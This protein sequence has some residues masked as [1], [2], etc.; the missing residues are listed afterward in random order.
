M[1]G[2]LQA[3]RLHPLR[4]QIRLGEVFDYLPL[5]NYHSMDNAAI[6]APISPN[7]RPRAQLSKELKGVIIGARMNAATF[8]KLQP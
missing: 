5:I 8:G 4:G 1:A 2:K 7:R 6:L 3:N